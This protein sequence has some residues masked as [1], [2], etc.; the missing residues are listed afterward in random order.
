MQFTRTALVDTELGGQQI[1]EGDKVCLF[2][3][4][5]NRDE[6]VFDRPQ[7]VGH[8]FLKRLLPRYK[9]LAEEIQAGSAVL[10]AMDA[11]AF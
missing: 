1:A 4:S 8:F 2:Y 7:D 10:M 6:S 9:S 5:G 11:A 3:C